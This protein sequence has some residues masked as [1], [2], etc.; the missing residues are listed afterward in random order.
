MGQISY[1]TIVNDLP[2]VDGGPVVIPEVIAEE[3]VMTRLNRVIPEEL[4][5]AT[6]VIATETTNS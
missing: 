4:Q 1:N 3:S 5:E 2:T 6:D